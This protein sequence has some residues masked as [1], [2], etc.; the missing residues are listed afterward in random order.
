MFLQQ[1]SGEAKHLLMMSLVFVI[2]FVYNKNRER[3]N[4]LPF[5]LYY[6]KGT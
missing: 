3:R 4:E 6:Y 1:L 5:I 2:W